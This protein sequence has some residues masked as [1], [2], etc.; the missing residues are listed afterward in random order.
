MRRLVARITPSPPFDIIQF[1]FSFGTDESTNLKVMVRKNPFLLVF[2]SAASASLCCL[3]YLTFLQGATVKHVLQLLMLFLVTVSFTTV[4]FAGTALAELGSLDQADIWADVSEEI[5]EAPGYEDP[6]D[7]KRN[8]A[9]TVGVAAGISP[10]YEGSNDYEFGLGPNFA[11]SWKKTVF[12][13]GKSLGA[14]L[15][16]RKN[17]K[18]GPILSWTSGRD[19]DDNDKLEGLGDVDSSVEAGGFVSYRHKPFRFRLE[20]RQD[21]GSGHDGALVEMSGGTTLPFQKPLVFAALGTTWASDD[22]MESFF[23]ID[24]KQSAESG[25]KRYNAEAGIKDVNISLTA[26]HAINNRWRVG[27]KLEY[28]R[29]VGDAADSPIVDDEN[30]FLFGITLTYRMGSKVLPEELQ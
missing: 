29:L 24:T 19:E 16:K 11:I 10:D 27:G 7:S 9:F 12:Y 23:G 28:K 15:I 1:S 18:A 4:I 8:W 22:Y 25:L 6:D 21:V 20:A 2:V 14:N 13:K 17:L 30:Q 5:D 3:S 26:G